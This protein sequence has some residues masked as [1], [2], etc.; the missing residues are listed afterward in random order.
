MTGFDDEQAEQLAMTCGADAFVIKRA[1]LTA[2]GRQIK[3]LLDADSALGGVAAAPA[4][5]RAKADRARAT[6]PAPEGRQGRAGE[7]RRRA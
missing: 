2:L 1:G 4:S 7:H 5:I 6:H 3:A